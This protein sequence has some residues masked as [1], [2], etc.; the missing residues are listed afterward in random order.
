MLI[1]TQI[2][3]HSFYLWCYNNFLSLA[4]DFGLRVGEANFGLANHPCKLNS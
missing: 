2:R 1:T 3:S 4:L